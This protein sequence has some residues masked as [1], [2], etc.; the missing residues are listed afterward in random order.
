MLR[1]LTL[2]MAPL[3]VLISV[4]F[5]NSAHKNKLAVCHTI[6]GVIVYVT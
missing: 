2:T 6:G 3:E 4:A 5:V 1:D